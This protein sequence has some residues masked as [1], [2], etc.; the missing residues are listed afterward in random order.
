M[1]WLE[2]SCQVDREAV[3]P[4][5]ELFAR[6]G[7]GAAIEEDVDSVEGEGPRTP[8][9]FVTVRTYLPLDEQADEKRLAIETGLWVLGMIRPVG[10]LLVRTLK[11]QDWAEAW[12][13]HFHVHRIGRRVVIKPSWREY[14]PQ[15]DDIVI[16]LDPGMA[17]GTGLH[18]TTQLCVETLDDYLK[19]GQQVLDLGT[20]SGILAIAAALL[21]ASSVLALDVD[22]LAV[23]AAR[24]N[25]AANGLAD[26]ISVENGSLPRAGIT[27]PFDLIVANI[28][29]HVLRDLAGPLAEA[30]APGGLLVASGIIAE[31]EAE[32]V[33]AFAD[34]GL[35]IVERR[36]RGDWVALVARRR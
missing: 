10:A 6:H 1:D 25:A 2:L 28:I 35:P 17:F 31:R 4:V 7:R 11:E 24:A 9:P 19:P 5:S 12:K 34:T 20:G 8:S 23:D 21:G 18:P 36:Q 15:P 22:P 33:T 14:D 27:T 13:A 16:Q 26:S 32:V 3:E 29:A 30:L